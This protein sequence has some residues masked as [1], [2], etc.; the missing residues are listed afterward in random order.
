MG[1]RLPPALT[2]MVASG[3]PRLPC[4]PSLPRR[5]PHTEGTTSSLSQ[6][7]RFYGVQ[8][9]AGLERAGDDL[10]L[11][12]GDLDCE[13]LVR[14]CAPCFRCCCWALSAAAAAAAAAAARGCAGRGALWEGRGRTEGGRLQ[15]LSC[16]PLPAVAAAHHRTAAVVAALPQMVRVPEFFSKQLPQYMR[17]EVGLQPYPRSACAAGLDCAALFGGHFGSSGTASRKGS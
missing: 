14:V 12:Y 2:S 9:V 3:P 11:S 10:W 1:S 5:L 15:P 7:D 17:G 16:F 8:F 13:S 6:S 4:C